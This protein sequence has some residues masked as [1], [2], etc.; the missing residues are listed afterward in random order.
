M[1]PASST[2]QVPT[3]E[4]KRIN[5]LQIPSWICQACTRLPL[6]F[7]RFASFLVI[8]SAVA[9]AAVDIGESLERMQR[10]QHVRRNA[11][12]IEDEMPMKEAASLNRISALPVRSSTMCSA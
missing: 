4:K 10:L 7:R 2:C 9:S 11:S 8:I 12:G 5:A 6:F 1:G 3:L